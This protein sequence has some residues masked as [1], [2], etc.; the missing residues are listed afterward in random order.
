MGSA[1]LPGTNFKTHLGSCG[2]VFV[3]CTKDTTCRPSLPGQTGGPIQ[4][5]SDRFSCSGKPNRIIS[6]YGPHLSAQK[7]SR[8]LSYHFAICKPYLG[9]SRR[10]SC[11]CSDE[12]EE[13]PSV[14]DRSSELFPKM[15]CNKVTT[16]LLKNDQK[17]K[18]L[19]F[20]PRLVSTLKLHNATPLETTPIHY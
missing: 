13:V 11:C 10:R 17:L 3:H 1:F 5:A 4:T 19:L 9:R 20:P 7:T 8:Q 2:P 6:I 15:Y 18:K 12:E 16:C 14:F